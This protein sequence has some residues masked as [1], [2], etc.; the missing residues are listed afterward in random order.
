MIYSFLSFRRCRIHLVGLFLARLTIALS[1]LAAIPAFDAEWE[2]AGWGG[3]VYYYAAA[4]HPTRDGVI[5]LAG[6]VGGV[7]RSEDVGESW[8]D[9][10]GDIPYNHPQILRYNP[11][12]RELWAGCVGLYKIKQ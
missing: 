11:L 4:F 10:T 8:Q 1:S 12:T 3:G 5:Y 2:H 7:H 9:M 6:D